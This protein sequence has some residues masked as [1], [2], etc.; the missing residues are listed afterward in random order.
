MDVL[1]LVVASVLSLT[2]TYVVVVGDRVGLSAEQRARGWNTASTGSA[3]FAFA[4]L[5]IVA[6]FWVT[7]R[8]ALGVLQGLLW[9]V[10]IV[11]WQA[12]LS[13]LAQ[14]LGWP[15][16]LALSAFAPLIPALLLTSLAAV[17]ALP[18][19]ATTAIVAASLAA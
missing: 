17:L 12:G 4:P 10:L 3:V 19:L 11:A 16:L 2:L 14:T 6:H 5:C 18:L 8:S 7:R 15:T 13:M 1:D 9:L